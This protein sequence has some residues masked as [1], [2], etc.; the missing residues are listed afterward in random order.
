MFMCY[1]RFLKILTCPCC[2]VP[3]VTFRN[4][5][6]AM[7][8]FSSLPQSTQRGHSATQLSL[9]PAALRADHSSAYWWKIFQQREREVFPWYSQA[10]QLLL[11]FKYNNF[12]GPFIIFRL[13]FTN[14]EIL[15]TPVASHIRCV[16]VYIWPP[17]H[18]IR[19][20][21]QLVEKI[22]FQCLIK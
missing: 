5:L 7:Q 14:I 20:W 9:P 19:P 22:F 3:N 4:E 12:N 8:F 16:Y 6:Q 2:T 11:C 15:A 17:N 1:W 13:L 10:D 18:Q 21:N